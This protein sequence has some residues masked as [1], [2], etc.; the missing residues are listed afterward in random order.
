[1]E[2][3]LIN[4]YRPQ[5]F[6]DIVGNEVIVESLHAA[7]E[8]ELS[9]SFLLV[10]PSGVGKTTA[11][12]IAVEYL[13]AERVEFDA[14]TNT[15]IDAMRSILT[16]AQF[17]PFGFK[18][19]VIIIDE[20]HA[21]S[22]AAWTSML[23]SVEEPPE[24]VFWFFC[25]SNEDKVPPNIRTRCH[26]L[27]F[28]EIGVKELEKLLLEICETEEHA[29]P[30]QVIQEIAYNSVGSAREAISNLSLCWNVKDVSEVKT[31]IGT[32]DENDDA[33]AVLCKKIMKDVLVWEDV[34]Q[35]YHGV[36]PTSPELVRRQICGY[37]TKVL[38]NN[39]NEELLMKVFS[40]L[41]HLTE[42][43]DNGEWAPLVMG[44][45]HIVYDRE[46]EGEENE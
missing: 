13:E 28:K 33:V 31:L 42:S 26:K 14:A 5:C 8:A 12:R 6:E 22:Q 37:L 46:E 25:T 3:S 10:G 2:N 17:K 20:C 30:K 40:A 11:A 39:T 4:K 1:M 43:C 21:L 19:K 27:I 15:G 38:L 24:G 44:L 23:K 41:D 29:L 35:M 45:A 34:Q 18:A 7:L 36:I 32:I 16:L 9:H